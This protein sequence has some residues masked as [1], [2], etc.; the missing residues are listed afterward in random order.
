MGLLVMLGDSFTLTIMN[1]MLRDYSE[2]YFA[3][4]S[5][6][7]NIKDEVRNADVIVLESCERLDYRMWD[8]VDNLI[9]VLGE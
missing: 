5:D 8:D 6:V 9:E 7:F 3:N 1:Y 2:S 4:R